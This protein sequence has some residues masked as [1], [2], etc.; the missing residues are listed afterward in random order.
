MSTP[1]NVFLYIYAPWYVITKEA[2]VVFV[3]EGLLHVFD[4]SV[5]GA[6][7]AKPLMPCTKVLRV[8]TKAIQ[9]Y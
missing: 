1:Y 8:C 6:H 3:C 7:I 4:R 5:T 9:R 2:Y